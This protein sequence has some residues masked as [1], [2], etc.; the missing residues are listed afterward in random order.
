MWRGRHGAMG[1]AQGSL[2]T[3]RGS[4]ATETL[5]EELMSQLH[6]FVTCPSTDIHTHGTAATDTFVVREWIEPLVAFLRHPFSICAG[7]GKRRISLQAKAF[8][9][10]RPGPM[11]SPFLLDTARPR[12]ILFDIGCGAYNGRRQ[13][14]GCCVVVVLSRCTCACACA[15]A[16]ACDCAC[17]CDC[18][19]GCVAVWLC[20]CDVL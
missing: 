11:V 9:A 7:F 12:R 2:N 17:S 16:C 1:F 13:K 18:A 8:L 4:V 5:R 20:G 3:A 14:V 15:C 10:L 19:C 6:Y